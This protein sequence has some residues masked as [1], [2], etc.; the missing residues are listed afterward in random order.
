MRHNAQRRSESLLHA[1]DVSLAT[2]HGWPK[3]IDLGSLARTR[4]RPPQWIVQSW[5]P[6][7]YATLLSGHGG[8]GKSAVA[9]HLAA[10]IALGL[11]WYGL[12]T[13]QRRVLFVSC[14]DRVD[15][16]H[17]RLWHICN[18]LGACIDDLSGRLDVI[19]LVGHDAVMWS[20]DALRK[21]GR[22]S[23]LD[24]L[25]ETMSATTA[26]VLVIDGISDSFAGS[27]INRAHVRAYIAGML[28]M[29]DPVRGA[30][31]LI[32]HVDKAT[33]IG[34]RT[35]NGYS[36]STAWNNSVRARWYLYPEPASPGGGLVL[37]Q[38]KANLG[39]A[40][41]RIRLLWD[42]EAHLFTGAL[43]TQ[44]AATDQIAREQRERDSI[45]AAM[46]AVMASG[47]YVPTATAGQRTSY[48]VLSARPEFDKVGMSPDKAGRR[49]FFDHIEVL[50]QLGEICEGTTTRA[51]RHKTSVLLL[52][53]VQTPS[54]TEKI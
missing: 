37:E 4:P 26:D 48:H 34:G 16:L 50:R 51:D 28:S 21:G 19:D 36:G 54:N 10:C 12:T 43:V 41:Q 46:R 3:P 8:T 32:G 17:W 2:N 9:L 7:G 25:Q 40:D 44:E 53:G 35:A 14:E 22:P 49:R 13:Y 24:E 27:E 47:H 39:P 45:L 18:H 42:K 20:E 5:M 11:P 15:V 30:V 23:A 29:I 1:E 33:A 6:S 38:Q 52:P 31:L